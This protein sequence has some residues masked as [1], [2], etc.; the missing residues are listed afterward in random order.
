[1]DF[2][3][4]RPGRLFDRHSQRFEL[5]GLDWPVLAGRAGA[6]DHLLTVKG[7]TTGRP[8]DDP[9]HSLVHP[10]DGREPTRARDALATP[11]DRLTLFHFA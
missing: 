2:G 11:A 7:L 1:L 10:L 6:G 3:P 9:Q 4:H 8:L 5:L